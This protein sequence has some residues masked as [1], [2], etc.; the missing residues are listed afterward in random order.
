MARFI[1]KRACVASRSIS[2]NALLGLLTNTTAGTFL[3]ALDLSDWR[4]LS[5]NSDTR[6][7]CVELTPDSGIRTL[8]IDIPDFRLGG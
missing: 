7:A 3:S 8:S 2:Q 4:I 1:P 6:E 5:Y